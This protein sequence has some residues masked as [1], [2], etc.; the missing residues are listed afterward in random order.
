MKDC[1]HIAVAML[2]ACTGYGAHPT[3]P[4]QAAQPPSLASFYGEECRGRPMAYKSR[5]FDPDALTCASWFYAFGTVLEVRSGDRI[6]QVEVTDRGPA[7]RLVDQGVVIDLSACAFFI[8]SPDRTHP[9]RPAPIPV[10][11][12][13]IRLP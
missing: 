6:V 9:M 13:V 2:V 1:R 10:S 5:P 3:R 11:I 12:R 4:Q 7:W 8:L